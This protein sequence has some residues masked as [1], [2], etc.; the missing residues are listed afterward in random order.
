MPEQEWNYSAEMLAILDVGHG[1]CAVITARGKTI[2]IDTGTG[3][4][5]LEFLMQA[6]VRKVD[7]V[8]ITHA[9]EDH[10][11]GL[12]GLLSSQVVKVG[13][14]CANPDAIKDTKVWKDLR[15][16][17]DSRSRAKTVQLRTSVSSSDSGFLDIGDISLEILA[18]SP[19]L[20]L[21]GPG[22]KSGKHRISSNTASI[23]LRLKTKTGP[24]ALLP[25]DLDD[26]ALDDLF[27]S[28]PELTAAYLVF[29]HHGGRAGFGDSK[30]FAKRLCKAVQPNTVIFSTGRGRYSTPHPDI[31]S[32]VL[33][34][35]PKCWIACTQLSQGC[36]AAPSKKKPTHLSWAHSRGREFQSCC[37]GSIIIPLDEKSHVSPTK[38]AHAGF[39]NK[40]VDNPMCRRGI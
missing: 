35:R 32:G 39:I 16:E 5:L 28:D 15:Y 27:R 20:L 26:I 23:V 11:G 19:L 9:D 6:E 38:R 33:E 12:I 37:A 1:N 2:V 34:E 18:P 29:P 14:V 36:S 8:V 40:H 7:F 21:G 25:G 13:C 3:S 22:S 24:I 10:I 17:L 30:G 31:V 4:A